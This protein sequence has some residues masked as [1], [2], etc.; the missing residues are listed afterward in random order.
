MSANYKLI[1]TYK[2]GPLGRL[3]RAPHAHIPIPA[4][5][6]DLVRRALRIPPEQL[7]SI[8][9]KATDEHV[10]PKLKAILRGGPGSLRGYQLQQLI[11]AALTDGG[12]VIDYNPQKALKDHA[13][14]ITHGKLHVVIEHN[15]PAI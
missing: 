2:T 14:R 4:F 11:F 10:G 5:L 12:C 7:R 3:V 6:V 13:I 1:V 15:P 9:P 8:F